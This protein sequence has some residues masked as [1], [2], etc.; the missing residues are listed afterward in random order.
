MMLTSLATKIDAID[1]VF[2]GFLVAVEFVFFCSVDC[3]F[4]FATRLAS[5]SKALHLIA[6]QQSLFHCRAVAILTQ[7]VSSR[8][9]IDVNKLDFVALISVFFSRKN[10]DLLVV[11]TQTMRSSQ[12]AA[13][14]NTHRIDLL[15]L[16]QQE[17]MK[18][19]S[20]AEVA[21]VV[22][23]LTSACLSSTPI[24]KSR[25]FFVFS[26]LSRALGRRTL[27]HE[28][29]H[30]FKSIRIEQSYNYS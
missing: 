28:R 3:V 7:K 20:R 22:H 29:A 19:S 13:L 4:G 17:R 2:G 1:G 14:Y 25:F 5:L 24:E 18:L 16:F 23:R 12:R 8:T 26:L 9:S 11:D 6:A 10:V 27:V 15:H 30:T 21:S